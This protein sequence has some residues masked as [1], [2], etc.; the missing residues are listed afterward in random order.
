MTKQNSPK[1]NFDR[2]MPMKNV[3]RDLGTIETEN[4]LL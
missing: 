2:D 4:L 1:L 3:G